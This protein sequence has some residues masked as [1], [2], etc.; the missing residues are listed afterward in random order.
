M[1]KNKIA[2]IITLILIISSFV[3]FVL[4]NG[5]E[6]R[7]IKL[8]KEVIVGDNINKVVDFSFDTDKKV[9]ITVIKREKQDSVSYYMEIRDLKNNSVT[10]R[11]YLGDEISY[12]DER[13]MEDWAGNVVHTGHSLIVTN[14]SK[15]YFLF[16]KEGYEFD[17][18]RIKKIQLSKDT[19]Y[20]NSSLGAVNANIIAKL[21]YPYLDAYMV[22]FRTNGNQLVAEKCK[23][24][25]LT[26]TYKE[27]IRDDRLYYPAISRSTLLNPKS[28]YYR[29]TD[30]FPKEEFSVEHKDNV[31]GSFF[32]IGGG[33]FESPK[34]I[35]WGNWYYPFY[36]NLY[37]PYSRIST[38]ENSLYVVNDYVLIRLS[39]RLV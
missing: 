29:F 26:D 35:Y 10:R 17:G 23:G 30:E 27:T 33:I 2:L 8:K 21:E 38:H 32:D 4:I 20:C 3:F 9:L 22:L 14:D 28:D 1:N 39:K 7:H 25:D 24:S 6:F 11:E 16:H 15:A 13:F 18:N 5:L 34:Y 37:F 31:G 36:G 12:F 19:V